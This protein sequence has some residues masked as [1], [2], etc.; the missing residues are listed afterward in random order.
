[1]HDLAHVAGWDPHNLH[2][3][4]HVSWVAHVLSRSLHNISQQQ[5]VRIHLVDDLDR[6][7]SAC[8]TFRPKRT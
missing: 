2:K 1:M 6:D 8:E 3:T 7:L 5:Q 4:E